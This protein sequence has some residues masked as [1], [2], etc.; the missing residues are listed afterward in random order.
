MFG[1][2]DVLEVQI[3]ALR[4]EVR[5]QVREH[6]QLQQVV[7]CLDIQLQDLAEKA[8]YSWEEPKPAWKKQ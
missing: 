4:A 3:A 8:G 7:R 1:R 2:R 5:L 6:E